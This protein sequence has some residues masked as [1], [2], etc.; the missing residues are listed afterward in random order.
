MVQKLSG[1]LVENGAIHMY[2]RSHPLLPQIVGDGTS[3]TEIGK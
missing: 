2:D 1:M 3:L